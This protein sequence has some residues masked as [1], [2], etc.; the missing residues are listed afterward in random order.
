VEEKLMSL[1]L[2]SAR[3]LTTVFTGDEPFVKRAV[4]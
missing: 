3:I 2:D 1:A 4:L